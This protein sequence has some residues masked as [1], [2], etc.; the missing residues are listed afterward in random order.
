MLIF[1]SL[2]GG[3]YSRQRRMLQ[4]GMLTL[5]FF[6]K[7]LFSP[8]VCLVLS[9]CMLIQPTYQSIKSLYKSID[10]PYTTSTEIAAP[11]SGDLQRQS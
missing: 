6:L 11:N 1:I 10:A 3:I 2:A 5:E 8:L 4:A 9:S 7:H